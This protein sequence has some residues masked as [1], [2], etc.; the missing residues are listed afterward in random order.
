[1]REQGDRGKDIR[2]CV[3]LWLYVYE[4]V[5]MFVY[6]CILLT[7]SAHHGSGEQR[8]RRAGG[9]GVATAAAPGLLVQDGARPRSGAH[10]EEERAHSVHALSDAHHIC[11]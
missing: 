10:R 2:N 6:M 9:E 5:F 4:F 11:K 3:C 7:S 8:A 1:M